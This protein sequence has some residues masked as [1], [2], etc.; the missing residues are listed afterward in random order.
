M[1]VANVAEDIVA[2]NDVDD[3]EDGEEDTVADAST[4]GKLTTLQIHC[5]SFEHNKGEPSKKKKK[6]KPKKKKVSEVQQTEPPRVGLSKLFTDGVYP[7]GEIQEYKD[8]CVIDNFS[9]LSILSC[10]QQCLEDDI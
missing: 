7:E 5:D 1:I 6:K 10:Q 2:Q 3:G 4:P 9:I 8:E